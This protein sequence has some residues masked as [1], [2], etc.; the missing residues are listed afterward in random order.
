MRVSSKC[1]DPN[2]TLSTCISVSFLSFPCV[3]VW[4]LAIYIS[5]NPSSY[6]CIYL[7]SLLYL[8]I[9]LYQSITLSLLSLY[10]N[11]CIYLQ[12][13]PFFPR[14]IPHLSPVLFSC[15]SYFVDLLLCRFPATKLNKS[16]TVTVSSVCSLTMHRYR[17]LSPP[18][19][20]SFSCRTFELRWPIVHDRYSLAIGDSGIHVRHFYT[21]AKSAI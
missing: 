21:G 1:L 8:Y 15:V 20:S 9:Y 12:S 4:Q 17:P 18:I 14:I 7:F 11:H 10:H 2:L 6:N 13:L 5:V 3:P 16:H 19:T